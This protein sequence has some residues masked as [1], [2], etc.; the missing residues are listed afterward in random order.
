MTVLPI[1]TAAFKRLRAAAREAL[2]MTLLQWALRIDGRA[3]VDVITRGVRSA[4]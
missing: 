4:R 2:A 3:V 1:T